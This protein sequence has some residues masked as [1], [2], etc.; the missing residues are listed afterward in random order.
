MQSSVMLSVSITGERDRVQ[1]TKS[2]K[3][4]YITGTAANSV[5]YYIPL[6]IK[7][8]ATICELNTFLLTRNTFVMFQVRK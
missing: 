4:N 7:Q 5:D 6:I 1:N 2:N 8:S 3:G